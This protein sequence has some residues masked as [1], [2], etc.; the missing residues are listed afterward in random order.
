MIGESLPK[1]CPTA[2]CSAARENGPRCTRN[3][4]N[5]RHST[6]EGCMVREVGHGMP[7]EGAAAA[8]PVKS[9]PAHSEPVA[10]KGKSA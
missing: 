6:S 10:R 8:D 4:H 1:Q 5:A 3:T 7:P 2:R 9:M